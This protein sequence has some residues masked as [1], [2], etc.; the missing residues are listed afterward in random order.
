MSGN[1]RKKVTDLAIPLA[2]DNLPAL[3]SNLASNR[4]NKSERKISRKGT[5]K[6]V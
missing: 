6:A 2:R 3:V 5:V 4:I 1:L